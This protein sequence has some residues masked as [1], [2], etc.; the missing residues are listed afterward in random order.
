MCAHARKNDN[1]C[2]TAQIGLRM[3]NMHVALLLGNEFPATKNLLCRPP[4]SRAQR[5]PDSLR[6]PFFLFLL[7]TAIGLHNHPSSAVALGVLLVH[8]VSFE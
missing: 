2:F 8:C 7:F 3:A 4:R 6:I 5:P 1:L